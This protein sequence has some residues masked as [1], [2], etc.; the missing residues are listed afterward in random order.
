MIT[1][2]VDTLDG[3]PPPVAAE[4]VSALVAAVLED[5]GSS[6]A[7]V[8]V[9]F[10]NDEYLKELKIRF[11][12]QAVYTDVIAFNPI[13]AVLL[14]VMDSCRKQFVDDAQQWCRVVVTRTR[15]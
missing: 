15:R 9:V 1:T 8:Q 13:V 6:T 14:G 4:S 7:G 12:G 5:A 2:Q 11:F 10:G 3:E